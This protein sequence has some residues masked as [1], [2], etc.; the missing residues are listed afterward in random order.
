MLWLGIGA[1]T[2][3]VGRLDQRC[4]SGLEDPE[5]LPYEFPGMIQMFDNMF[6]VNPVCV[7]VWKRIR[8]LVQIMDHVCLR[9]RINVDTDRTGNFVHLAAEI[10][11]NFAIVVHS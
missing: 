3:K 8:K 4:S 10:N 9:R 5:D 2:R 11:N 7:M 6:C 1:M